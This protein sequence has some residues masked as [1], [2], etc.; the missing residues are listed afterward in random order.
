LI[1]YGLRPNDAEDFTQTIRR[2]RRLVKWY[3]SEVKDIK[4]F[5]TR[6]FLIIPLLLALGWPEQKLKIEWNNIDIA[7]FE[8]PYNKKNLPTNN[9]IIILESKRLGE[10]LT[11][12]ISQGA[13]YS[14]KYSK[15][16]RLIVTDGCRYRLYKK[17]GNNW[18]YTAYLNILKPRV[19]HP[20]E[21]EIK[22][23][24]DVFLNLMA[25]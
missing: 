19:L 25:R 12:A 11:F 3:D 15:C 7:F 24:S 1:S 6:T 9:C 5:E 4:E 8:K 14:K 17:A 22:G 10:G 13:N 2:I 23:A 18:Q 16:D 21:K 20:Y